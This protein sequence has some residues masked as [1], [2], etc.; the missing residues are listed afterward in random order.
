MNRKYLFIAAGIIAALAINIVS[1]LPDGKLHVYFLDVGQGDSALVRT[2]SNRFILIDGGPDDSVLRGVGAVMPFYERRIDLVILTH[3]HPDHINGL[4]EVLKRY[5][6]DT[7]LMTGINYDYAG[8]DEFLDLLARDN[9][10]V[11]FADGHDYMFDTTMIDVIY[12]F[13]SLQGRE[14]E[15]INNSSIVFRLIYGESEFYFSGDAE[16]PVEEK[17]TAKHPDIHADVLKV[18]HHG[19]RTASS[20]AL[21]DMIHPVYAVISVGV[22]NQFKHP[23]KETIDTLTRENVKILRTDLIGA[24]EFESDGKNIIR[25]D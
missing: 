17:I 3:P 4:V 23:H 19:S 15:N 18:P 22:D 7:V 9:T 10:K 6:V 1:T 12:P 13:D 11:F 25:K 14:F 21:V 2:P 8:Y 16:I 20:K 24:I 5:T